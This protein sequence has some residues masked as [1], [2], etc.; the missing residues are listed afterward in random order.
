MRKCPNCGGPLDHPE[1]GCVLAS[2]IQIIR[3]R[4]EHSV[5]KVN[6]LHANCDVDRLWD[7]VGSIVNRLAQGNYNV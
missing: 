4:Q 5:R 3:E 2:L 6:D 7:D 1:N